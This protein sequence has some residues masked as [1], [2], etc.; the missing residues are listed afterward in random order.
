VGL[1]EKKTIYRGADGGHVGLP[2][3][4]D[5][6]KAALPGTPK[7]DFTAPAGMEWADIDRYTGLLATA[8]TTDKVLHL[9]FKPGTVPKSG[10]DAD[11]IKK[12]QE[13]RAKAPSQ[14]VE[15][16]IWGRPKEVEQ[17]KPVNLNTSDPNG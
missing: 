17:P 6:M 5:F 10:S 15:V 14:P 1:Y 9:A 16:R 3:W 13:A 12:I 2:I 8:A 11:T 4:V 7:E